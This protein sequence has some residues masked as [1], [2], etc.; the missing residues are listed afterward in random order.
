MI[1]PTKHISADQSLLG[2]GAIL[3]ADLRHPTTVSALWDKVKKHPSVGSYERYVL[4]LDLLYAL[5]AV[6]FE[7]GLLRRE[8][9]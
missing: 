3:L 1:L 6:A 5:G 7:N 9:K 4:T 8:A 2:V